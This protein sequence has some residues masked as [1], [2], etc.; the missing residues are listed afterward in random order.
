MPKYI[1]VKV[2]GHTNELGEEIRLNKCVGT[3][4]K[5]IHAT[6]KEYDIDVTDMVTETQYDY[7]TKSEANTVA[8]IFERN[9]ARAKR[10]SAVIREISGK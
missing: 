1:I 3:I 7:F 6:S 9:L 4:R 5:A 2:Y 8:G 10:M